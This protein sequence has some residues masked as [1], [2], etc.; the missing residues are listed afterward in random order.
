MEINKFVNDLVN[1]DRVRSLLKTI[2]YR[3]RFL[4]HLENLRQ[5]QRI[6]QGN[7]HWSISF[8]PWF[9]PFSI[10]LRSF[11]P[12]VPAIIVEDIPSTPPLSTRDVTLANRDSMGFFGEISSPS[13]SPYHSPDFSLASDTPSKSGRGLRRNRRVSD[14]SMLSTDL[15]YQN[16]Y[17]LSRVLSIWELIV[18]ID[19]IQLSPV[20]HTM[21][22]LR[23]FSH[24][25]KTRCGEV[26]I[27]P[28][29]T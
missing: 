2:Y 18:C 8:S 17:V 16:P 9:P 22:I 6:E 11:S 26:S 19:L 12:G 27:L 29:L 21:R 20:N 1:L 25:C 4:A 3:R 14:I 15:G 5:Q 23:L 28:F 13:P 10:I 7:C 24:Q